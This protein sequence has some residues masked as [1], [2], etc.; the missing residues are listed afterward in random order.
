RNA[1]SFS[2]YRNE[3][4]EEDDDLVNGPLSTSSRS[5]RLSLL[6]AH[7]TFPHD[8]ELQHALV[9]SSRSLHENSSTP[10]P[11]H[12][13]KS[14]RRPR[15]HTRNKSVGGQPSQYP[16][17]PSEL[18]SAPNRHH[19][20]SAPSGSAPATPANNSHAHARSRTQTQNQTTNS[21]QPLHQQP[22]SP[23]GAFLPARNT[24]PSPNPEI[25]PGAS[26]TSAT[27]PAKLPTSARRHQGILVDVDAVL[28]GAPIT[29]DIDQPAPDFSTSYE[30][31]QAREQTALL[32]KFKLSI[33]PPIA[34]TKASTTITRPP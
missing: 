32:D 8:K 16:V 30:Q 10:P 27:R 17:R 12:S 2:H 13:P 33:A 34:F 22:D 14:P 18:R 3:S 29:H 9:A 11:L 19:T 15:G 23:F 1:F 31:A 21:P 24:T 28:Q 6:P 4:L 20:I 26:T 7:H 5:L 25:G